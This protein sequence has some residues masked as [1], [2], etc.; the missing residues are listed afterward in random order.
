LAVKGFKPSLISAR[1]LPSIERD[2]QFSPA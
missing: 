1:T 2:A